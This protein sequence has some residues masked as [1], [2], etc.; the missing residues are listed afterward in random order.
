MT[1]EETLALFPSTKRKQYASGYWVV[2][3]GHDDHN[4]SL[5]IRRGEKRAFLDCRACQDEDKVCAAVGI[6][7]EDLWYTPLDESTRKDGKRL[8]SV[9]DYTGEQGELLFQKLRYSPKKPDGFQIRRPNGSGGWI[10][11][12]GKTRRVPY[13]LPEVIRSEFV[14]VVEGEKA[15]D[16]LIEEGL[17]A[18]CAMFGAGRW[19]DELTKY[20]KGKEVVILE[21]N[22]DEGKKHTAVVAPKLQGTAGAV[23][24]ILLDG[25]PTGG[26]VF[27]WF[28]KGHTAEELCE[29]AERAEK[30]HAV[31][32]ET[33]GHSTNE[34]HPELLELTDL[35]NAER[36]IKR[37]GSIVKWCGALEKSQQWLIWDGKH[38]Q[39]D[40]VLKIKT[41]AHQVVRLIPD[42]I[43]LSE[44]KEEQKRIFKWAH[45]SQGT[46]RRE[47]MVKDARPMVAVRIHSLD[48]DPWL[49]NVANGTLN[50]RTG[51]L[52]NHNPDD[53]LTRL[54]D[55][56]FDENAKAPQWL[57]FLNTV[58]NGNQ[59]MVDF[60]QRIVG[61]TLTGDVS[62]KMMF[63]MYGGTDT[64][65]STFIETMQALIGPY[66]MKIQTET[67]MKRRDKNASNDIARLKGAR[68]VHA[69]ET[70]EGEYL[71]TA[72]IKELTGGDTIAARFLFSEVFQFEPEFKLWLS[73]N[74]KPNVPGGDDAIWR[75]LKEIPFAV[76]IPESKQ[77]KAL[78]Q[79]L[80]AELPGILTWAVEGCFEWL[81][82]GI[83]IP[84]EVTEATGRY[85]EQMDTIKDF[86][87]E[88]TEVGQGFSLEARSLY[89]SYSQWCKDAGE[90]TLSSRALGLRLSDRG[91]ERTK[92][93]GGTRRW[94]GLR[95]ISA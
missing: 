6:S 75:R 69:S 59:R 22:D 33:N 81:K 72:L 94:S 51:R 86:L 79:K 39:P 17:C 15:A 55:V 35:G 37:F 3:P 58:Q 52:R 36:F 7:A 18:T 31:K 24:A 27:D 90:R 42:E 12:L 77:D 92:G 41:L 21:D 19:P 50:L 64:G 49:L 4:P 88:C 71:A 95:L 28:Q 9:H 5:N 74:H 48:C 30:W 14:F 78:K 85:R 26:D 2:C 80:R 32:A 70:E 54:I 38:W 83:G 13:N 82:G 62:E 16:R 87:D 45:E 10:W 65:K 84:E 44:D 23:K 47:N 8:V 56:P 60:L 53:L 25:L 66:A 46:G 43:K 20:F 63:V 40:D 1:F 34:F 61:Y 73:T 93:T 68:L 11:N 57:E 29:I 89:Q 91:F 76:R 67:L